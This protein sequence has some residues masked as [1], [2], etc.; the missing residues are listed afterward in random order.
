MGGH[1]VDPIDSQ[2]AMD[3][4]AC[5]SHSCT[6]S[7]LSETFTYIQTRRPHIHLSS[8][9]ADMAMSWK[10]T[11]EAEWHARCGKVVG[12]AV[13]SVTRVAAAALEQQIKTAGAAVARAQWLGA[14]RGSRRLRRA[15]R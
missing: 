3:A 10:D 4:I 1:G 11:I 7:E 2:P 15:R 9:S 12:D 14:H 8:R 13:P 5:N 6:C